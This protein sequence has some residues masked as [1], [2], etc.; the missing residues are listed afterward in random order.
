MWKIIWCFF[1]SILL[2]S[3]IIGLI[4]IPENI[5]KWINLT[6]YLS[7]QTTINQNIF[8]WI[9]LATGFLI[10]FICSGA[11]KKAW[12]KLRRKDTYSP[13]KIEVHEDGNAYFRV[14]DETRLGHLQN[15]KKQVLSIKVR[16]N[17]STDNVKVF[18]NKIETKHEDDKFQNLLPIY[19]GFKDIKDSN[20]MSFSADETQQVDVVS[21]S[22]NQGCSELQL[23]QFGNAENRGTPYL[24]LAFLGFS[25]W[26]FRFE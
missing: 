11:Y 26:S 21:Y 6:L 16:A 10:I 12:Q 22:V 15:K 5:D 8:Q 20:S 2:I 7:M 1:S 13:L 25:P 23:E 18:V 3:G 19:L 4:N 24:F 9:F 14:V 17:V